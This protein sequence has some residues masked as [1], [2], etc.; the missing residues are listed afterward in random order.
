V[1]PF[2]KKHAIRLF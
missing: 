2:P 1:A